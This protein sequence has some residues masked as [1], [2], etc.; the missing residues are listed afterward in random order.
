MASAVTLPALPSPVPIQTLAHNAAH[1]GFRLAHIS[2]VQSTPVEPGGLRVLAGCLPLDLLN[3]VAC[4][5]SVTLSCC[6]DIL[7][8]IHVC[9][10]TA[11]CLF[12]T[13]RDAL[14]IVRFVN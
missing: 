11:R 5:S 8:C 3:L 7:L 2:A 4:A 12:P 6:H 1:T 14:P 9:V 13:R 10:A